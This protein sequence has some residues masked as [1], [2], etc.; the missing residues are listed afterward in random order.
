MRPPAA[1]LTAIT[2]LCSMSAIAQAVLDLGFTTQ[3]GSALA[4]EYGRRF[5]MDVMPRFASWAGFAQQQKA[6]P[7]SEALDAAAGKEADLL[8]LVN[9]DTNQRVKWVDDQVHWQAIDYGATP[10]ESVATAGGD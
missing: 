10:A 2:L 3:A 8:Q 6:S 5:K 7:F 1:T 9:D 4:S